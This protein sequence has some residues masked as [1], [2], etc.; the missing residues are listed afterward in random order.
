MKTLKNILRTGAFVGAMAFMPYCQKDDLEPQLDETYELPN[1]KNASEKLIK[2]NLEFPSGLSYGPG[3]GEFV[4][5]SAKNFINEDIKGSGA[6]LNLGT[7]LQ[8][9]RFLN[10]YSNG[11]IQPKDN[12]KI[13]IFFGTLDNLEVNSLAEFNL[14]TYFSDFHSSSYYALADSLWRSRGLTLDAIVY[15]LGLIVSSNS[16]D[17]LFR[18][19]LLDGVS[20]YMQND[21]L[22]GITDMIKG[23]DGKIYAVQS[24]QEGEN[25]HPKRVISIDDNKNINVEFELPLDL[26][27]NSWKLGYAS[28]ESEDHVFL[29]NL[30]IIENSSIGRKNF[31][32][33]FYISD[34]LEDVIYK[35][36]TLKNVEDLVRGINLPSSLAVDSIGDLF[37]TS[38]P[39]TN[40]ASSQ[41][42]N[43]SAALHVLNP[44]TGES[45]LIK[46]FGGKTFKDYF[47]IGGSIDLMAGYLRGYVAPVGFNVSNRLFETTDYLNFLITN[48]HQ[49]TLN[50][51]R[52]QKE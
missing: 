16:S 28:P 25:E 48:S 22:R 49:G 36:D 33:M 40:R 43:F 47:G 18:V 52:L 20:V 23:S 8:G 1:F 17:K 50:L 44:E 6:D 5:K 30:K 41:D 29:E 14:S 21:K 34:L 32:N 12:P 24:S 37:Y 10:L 9:P 27:V 26:N 11:G 45:K 3:S 31:G 2:S 15:N 19:G 13:S 46:E 42:L 35:V 39:L 4:I 51:I 38:S 7:L